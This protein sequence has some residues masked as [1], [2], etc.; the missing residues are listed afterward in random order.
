M[1]Y[2]QWAT[3]KKRKT[4]QWNQ[5]NNTQTKWEVNRDIDITQ[6]NQTEILEL[7]DAM[8]EMKNT[9]GNINS[10]RLDK[11]K[12]ESMKEKAGLKL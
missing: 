2:V 7:K 12:K 11:Q 3:R 6:K 10:R 8:N 9:I 5:E 4:I 1:F